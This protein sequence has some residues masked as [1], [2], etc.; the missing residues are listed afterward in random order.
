MKP[1][2]A[3]FFKKS[4]AEWKKSRT[5]ASVLVKPLSIGKRVP[6]NASL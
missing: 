4:E 3:C 6:E 5:F 2:S 1:C